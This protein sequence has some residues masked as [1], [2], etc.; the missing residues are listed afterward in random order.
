[1]I[2]L[3]PTI[4]T[5]A[6]ACLTRANWHE[7]NINT[8]ACA[9]DYLLMKPGLHYLETLAHIDHYLGDIGDCILDA[10]MLVLNEQKQFIIRSVYD[11]SRISLSLS[12]FWALVE[13]LNPYAIV[14]PPSLTQYELPFL[15]DVIPVFPF[16]QVSQRH[17][18][19]SYGVYGSEATVC[20]QSFEKIKLIYLMYEGVVPSFSV[21]SCSVPI[22]IAAN[23]PAQ[24]AYQGIVYL[25]TGPDMITQA[26]FANQFETLIDNCTCPICMQGFTKAYLHHLFQNTP[27]LCQRLLIMHNIHTVYT[28]FQSFVN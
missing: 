21:T 11:G 2:H 27:L 22:Y 17:Y 13:Q 4:T 12:R 26:V 6:G 14:L 20:H 3:V 19:T 16:E 15:R 25:K 10:S 18:P 1:M 5:P 8:V 23:Q 9:L 7:L 24:D 28:R